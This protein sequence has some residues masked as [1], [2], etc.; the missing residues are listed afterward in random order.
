M[1]FLGGPLCLVLFHCFKN[2]NVF[3]YHAI[4]CSLVKNWDLL[5]HIGLQ[6]KFFFL[7]HLGFFNYSFSIVWK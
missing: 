2:P 5:A 4:K 3:Y 7:G 1:I 6:A